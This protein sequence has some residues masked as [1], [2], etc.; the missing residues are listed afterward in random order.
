MKTQKGIRKKRKA[1]AERLR[2]AE[3]NKNK[4]KLRY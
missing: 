4:T 2:C 3:K 1:M